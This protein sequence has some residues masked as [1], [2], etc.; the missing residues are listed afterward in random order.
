MK[1]KVKVYE[2]YRTDTH[3]RA[4]HYTACPEEFSMSFDKETTGREYMAEMPDGVRIGRL[5]S[6]E[7]TLIDRYDRPMYIHRRKD[8][9]AYLVSSFVVQE[10]GYE[11]HEAILYS[12]TLEEC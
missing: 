8:G 6:G 4:Y 5:N 10:M 2:Y 11:W 3:D 1:T 7:Q 9:T 12:I